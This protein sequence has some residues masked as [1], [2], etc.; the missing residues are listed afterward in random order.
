MVFSQK[1]V[2]TQI[3]TRENTRQTTMRDMLQKC[4]TGAPSTLSRLWKTRKGWKLHHTEE[5]CRHTR[6]TMS[7]VIQDL[8]REVKKD[9]G[10]KTE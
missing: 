7:S 4:L 1:P 6:E 3:Y 8:S 10:G 9:V 5:D 2:I